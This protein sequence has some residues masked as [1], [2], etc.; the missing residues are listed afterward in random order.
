MQILD[1]TQE[2]KVL[3]ETKNDT[4]VGSVIGGSST[5]NSQLDE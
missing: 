3:D 5:K 1:G 2:L 4:Y